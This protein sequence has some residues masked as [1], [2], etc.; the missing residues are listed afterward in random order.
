MMHISIAFKLNAYMIEK[1]LF[2]TPGYH[3]QGWLHSNKRKIAHSHC[4]TLHI[5]A[6]MPVH[7]NSAMLQKIL[8]AMYAWQ[9][10]TRL[11]Y[12]PAKTSYYCWKGHWSHISKRSDPP[13]WARIS[14]RLA[15]ILQGYIHCG[16]PYCFQLNPYPFTGLLMDGLRYSFIEYQQLNTSNQA[17]LNN[18]T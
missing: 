17:T 15:V 7:I 2:S 9:R 8:I 18:V 16:Y 14:I 1:H 5:H 4:C 12:E 3:D 13:P 10:F 11:R 6:Y